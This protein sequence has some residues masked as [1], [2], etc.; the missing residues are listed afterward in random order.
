MQSLHVCCNLS[1][2]GFS[3]SSQTGCICILVHVN[4][5]VATFHSLPVFSTWWHGKKLSHV[6][7]ECVSENMQEQNHDPNLSVM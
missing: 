1:I 7:L 5:H 3:F 2:Y 4:M 6:T